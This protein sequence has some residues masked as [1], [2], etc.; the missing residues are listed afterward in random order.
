MSQ[1]VYFTKS[2]AGANSAG[3]AASQT[4]SGAGN[5]TL[6]ASPVVLDTPRQVLL[7]FAADETGHTFTITGYP[8]ITASNTPISETIAGT[9]GTVASTRMY[10]QVTSIAISDAAAGAIT[11][12]TNGVGAS[13]WVSSNYQLADANWS[14][15]CVVAGT[16]NFTIQ[17]TYDDFW[18]VPFG[19]SQGSVPTA[20]NDPILASVTASGETTF[21]NPITGWRLLINSGTGSVAVRAVEAG[22]A[23]GA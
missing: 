9:A 12:G 11:A 14:I 4:P 19:Q 18:S 8:S 2:L 20:W 1:S 10:G 13:H 16:V 6:T 7:T 3:I 17:Y 21:G 23:E 5:L 15:G 22:I